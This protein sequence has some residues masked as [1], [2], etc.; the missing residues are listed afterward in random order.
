MEKGTVLFF[1]TI[2]ITGIPVNDRDPVYFYAVFLALF[3]TSPM[4]R[5]EAA[6]K[7]GN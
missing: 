2:T 4:L 1:F 3:Y 7:Y 6:Q 5:A